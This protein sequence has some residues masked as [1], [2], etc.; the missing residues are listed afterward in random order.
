MTKNKAGRKDKP[1]TPYNDG[2]QPHQPTPHHNR[3]CVVILHPSNPPPH[4]P[5][6]NQPHHPLTHRHRNIGSPPHS[7]STLPPCATEH[8]VPYVVSPTSNTM[9]AESIASIHPRQC[10]KE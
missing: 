1:S 3:C 5:P 7:H 10:N 6:Y 4:S 2:R 8:A 9:E